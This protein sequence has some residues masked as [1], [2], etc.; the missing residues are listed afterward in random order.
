MVDASPLENK[1]YTTDVER[2]ASSVSD[3]RAEDW[4]FYQHV[5]LI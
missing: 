5:S 3:R 1:P 4:G 2:M